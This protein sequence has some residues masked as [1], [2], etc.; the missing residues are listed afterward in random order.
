MIA[1]GFPHG[2]SSGPSSSE[3]S[4]PP[5]TWQPF[6]SLNTAFFILSRI[7]QPL[8]AWCIAVNI[9]IWAMMGL[10]PSRRPAHDHAVDPRCP[11]KQ[12]KASVGF[13]LNIPLPPPFRHGL[14]E[15]TTSSGTPTVCPPSVLPD[16]PRARLRNEVTSSI[17]RL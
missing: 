8:S 6:I 10:I 7:I 2:R 17:A 13:S 11:L 12:Q 9:G 1:F 4:A 15:G 3:T 14:L 5:Q 16:H